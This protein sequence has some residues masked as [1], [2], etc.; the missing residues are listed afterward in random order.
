[1]P[2][3]HHRT[4][5]KLRIREMPFV[6]PAERR[7]ARRGSEHHGISAPDLDAFVRTTQKDTTVMHTA[8]VTPAPGT[9]RLADS[10]RSHLEHLGEAVEAKTDLHARV[11]QATQSGPAVLR[12]VN[13][14]APD[15]KEDLE[16]DLLDG[17]WSLVWSWGDV[18]GSADDIEDAVS[19]IKRV[20]TVRS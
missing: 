4:Q 17:R 18:L 8:R 16:C 20:L 11:R 6:R 5:C 7:R 13:P 12:I 9:P 19:A 1:V 14:T 3:H 15:L 10:R 2:R